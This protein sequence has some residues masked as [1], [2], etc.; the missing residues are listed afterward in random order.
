MCVKTYVRHS[1]GIKS[2]MLEYSDVSEYPVEAF[3][4]YTSV[5]NFTAKLFLWKICKRKKSS[6]TWS[7]DSNISGNSNPIH[8]DISPPPPPPPHTHTH[9]SPPSTSGPEEID[10][11]FSVDG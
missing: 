10:Y 9:T 6:L 4:L 2:I 11:G 5:Q 3:G 1:Q 8:C 7:T